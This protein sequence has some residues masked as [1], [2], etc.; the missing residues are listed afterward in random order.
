MKKILKN[1]LMYDGR[2]ESEIRK[3][4]I[5]IEENIIKEISDEIKVEGNCEILDL[6]GKY[7]VPGLVNL[8]AH[9]FGSGKPSK[10]LGG[11]SMQ[12][13]ILSF[14]GT[15]LGDKVLMKLVKKNVLTALYSGVTT[16]RSSGDFYYSDVR[17]KKL[18]NEKKALGPKLIVPGYAIT[19]PTGHGDGTFAKTATTKEEFENLVKQ[20]KEH[21]VDYIK[22][23]VTGGVMDATKKGSPGELKMNLEQTKYV[24]DAAHKYGMTVASHTESNPGIKVACA[25]GVDTIEHGGF[26]EESDVNLLK[27]SGSAQV[28][29]LSPAIPLAK[30]DPKETKLNDICVYNSNFIM[31]GMVDG[32]KKCLENGILVGLGTDASCPFVPQCNMWREIY[33]FA[34]HVG[35]D[36]KFALHTA[37]YI[38]SKIINREAEIGSIEVG[39]RA[40]MIVLNGNP[41]ENLE[42]LR[43]VERVV[44]DGE[45]LKK[46]KI[47]KNKYIEKMLDTLL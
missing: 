15:K 20:N 35:V 47:K 28:V 37:T 36:N 34:K 38:N 14:V 19:V 21:G 42:A 25:G 26:L 11:G 8:H 3:V 9:L 4:D 7:V 33:F 41:L 45:I 18:I 43:N 1:C 30:F 6:D 10:I 24:C 23:C 2:L 32:A 39:K 27:N 16:L 17:V 12:K 40:D 22:I 44:L 46:K 29:T 5:L 31:E 13:K